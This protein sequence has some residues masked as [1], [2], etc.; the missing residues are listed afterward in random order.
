MATIE[1]PLILL[2]EDEPA[3]REVLSYNL[4]AEMLG[5]I[6]LGL[7]LVNKMWRD[8][9]ETPD[10]AEWNLLEP[11]SENVR[12]H[13]LHL[14]AAHHG[15][16]E[17]GS[18]VLPKTPEAIALHH[19][20]NIDAK[21]EMFRRAYETGKELGSGIIERFTPWPVNIVA[22]LPAVPPPTAASED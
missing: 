12:L 13:L 5:H 17:F 14:I 22:P 7:E 20:D 16:L 15:S 2:V 1:H 11:A 18:P 10:A 3:Q 4:T 8:M 9:M 21:L 6:P 19:V